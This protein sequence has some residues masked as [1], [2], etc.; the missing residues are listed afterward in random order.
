MESVGRERVQ[1][2]QLVVNGGQPWIRGSRGARGT[3]R[4]QSM[5]VALA[6]VL[7][8]S[9]AAMGACVSLRGSTMCPAFQSASVS[10]EGFIAGR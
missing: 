8:A 3:S 5:K 1:R 6:S 9:P 10:T 4:R 7:A 2:A